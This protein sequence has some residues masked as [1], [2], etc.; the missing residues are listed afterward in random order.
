MEAKV[1]EIEAIGTSRRLRR[2]V[3]MIAVVSVVIL[4]F[5]GTLTGDARAGRELPRD[6]GGRAASG[7]PRSRYAPVR[8]A[9]AAEHADAPPPD[10]SE[11]EG[12]A[13]GSAS[14]GPRWPRVV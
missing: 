9:D 4:C 11:S 12:D 6:R 3:P 2:K 13:G 1:E 8:A 10:D 5:V 14:A 7:P